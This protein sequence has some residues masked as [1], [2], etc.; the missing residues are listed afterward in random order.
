MFRY[1]VSSHLNPHLSGV[2][3]FN[4][5]LAERLRISCVG[6]EQFFSLKEGP[7]LLSIKLSDNNGFELAQV[8]N[9]L[10]HATEKN[11]PYDI[12]FHT[13]EGLEVERQ[14]LQGCRQVFCGNAEIEDKLRE[15]GKRVILAWC[16]SLIETETAVTE[17]RLNLFSFGMAHK[18]QVKYYRTLQ[19]LLQKCG[20]DYSLWVSTAFH[21]KANF[22]E[23]DSL[24]SRLA[25]IFGP[26]IQFLGFLSDEAVNYFLRKTHLFAAFF[27]KGV[28]ANN[29]TVNAAMARGCAVLTNCDE[30]SPQWLQHGKNVLDIHRVRPEDLHLDLLA[31]IGKQAQKDARE[32][33]SWEGLVRLLGV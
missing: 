3:K 1:I 13:F 27:E 23:F 18:L 32:Y 20:T 19:E 9:F 4:R 11:I 17:S 33:A 22:G 7:L 6:L 8:K 10:S 26:R 15:S 30:Y 14:L 24:S 28:R 5:L 12:F 29:T 2:A 16:P 21:E 25:E 31:E